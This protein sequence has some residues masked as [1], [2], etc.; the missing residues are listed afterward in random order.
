MQLVR[1]QDHGIDKALDNKLI[2]LAATWKK[3]KVGSIDIQNVNRTFGALLGAWPKGLV[4]A[5]LPD[6]TIKDQ[7][8]RHRR[9]SFGAWLAH[10]VTIDLA[11]EGNDYVGKGCRAAAW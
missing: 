9:Q 6:D 10:G 11:G 2:E 8:Q 1:A 3:A 5:G 4:F 7:R